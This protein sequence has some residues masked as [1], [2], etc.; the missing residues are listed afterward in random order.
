MR[1][2]SFKNTVLLINGL[3]ITGWAEGDDVIKVERFDDSTSHV[4]GAGGEMTVAL[5]AD[6]SGFF[7]FNLQ[8]SSE[9]NIYLTALV[10]AQETGT[11]VPVGVAWKDTLGG[12]LMSGA[13][14][15]IPRP[16][17]LQR[18]SGVN[19]QLWRVVVE[20]LD[21]IRGGVAAL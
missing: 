19:A 20:R 11:F 9:S 7:E 4:I 10:A 5:S 12:D 13:Q 14:G 8:Q 17:N 18:G 21:M 2:Y 16:A 6:R 1:P 15:Y 3:E